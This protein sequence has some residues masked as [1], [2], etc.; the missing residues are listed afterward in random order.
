MKRALGLMILLSAGCAGEIDEETLEQT[1]EGLSAPP[2]DRIVALDRA[3]TWMHPPIRYSNNAGSAPGGYRADCS[4]F[5]SMAWTIPPPGLTTATLGGV[6][7]VIG[8]EELT[9]GDVMLWHNTSGGMG[10]VVLFERWADAAHTAYWAYEQAGSPYNGTAHR[11]VRYPYDNGGGPYI[12]HR[13]NPIRDAVGGAILARYNALGGSG[14]FLG[15]ALTDETGTPD[16]V[17]RYN[18]FQGGSIYWTPA[19]DAHEVHGDIRIHWSQ[20]GWERSFLGYP[21]TDESGTPDGVG[22]FNHFQ[23][24]SIYWTPAHGAHELHGAIGGTWAQMGWERSPL[25]YPTSDEYS[26]PGGRRSDFEHGSLVWDEQTG[27]VS[28]Q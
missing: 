21:I 10:H 9:M 20:L 25:G 4:G 14:G 22:R 16:G 5:V 24:G 17:G 13:Y 18:H 19:T 26:V 1:S 12:P 7:H 6:S 15:R 3:E 27:A 23:Y 2:V 28:M 11:I 8:K